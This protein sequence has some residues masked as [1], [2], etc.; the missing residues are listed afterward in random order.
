VLAVNAHQPHLRVDLFAL[1]DL[2][3]P[4]AGR[5]FCWMRVPLRDTPEE[6]IAIHFVSVAAFIEEALAVGGGVLVHCHAG[7][8]R[9][10]SLVLAWLMTRR[11]W[12]LRRAIEFLQG[13]R[14]QAA[15]NAGYMAALLRLEED[16]F[17][18]QTVKVKR[19]K[20]E[21][22]VCPECGDKVGLSE[23][24][25]QVHLRLKHP[26][27]MRAARAEAEAAAMADGADIVT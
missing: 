2:L 13:Q 18:K 5:G 27:V 6:D 24:S 7:Q 20:P 14:P 4:D 25:L 8:S 22:R 3:P 11:K 9:S 23:Q 19:T 26:E 1:Q 10:C 15:P 16:L 21:S 12:T 17:G